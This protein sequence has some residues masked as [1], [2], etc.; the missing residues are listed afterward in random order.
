MSR[1]PSRTGSLRP[2]LCAVVLLAGAAHAL[3]QDGPPGRAKARACAICHGALGISTQ[4]DAPNLAGQPEIYVSAQLKAY[5]SGKRAHEVMNVIAKPLSDADVPR[6]VEG[7]FP[8]TREERMLIPVKL[9]KQEPPQDFAIDEERRHPKRAG[10]LVADDH[11]AQG[12]RDDD[13]R[14][15]LDQLPGKLASRRLRALRP[16]EQTR[17]LEVPI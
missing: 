12:R 9:L 3:A 17:A 13:G 8:D 6:L 14:R 4:P 16:H 15:V 10:R 2:G 1:N 5:R 7:Q 11:A